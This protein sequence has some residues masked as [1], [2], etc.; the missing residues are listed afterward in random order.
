MF[1]FWMEHER[2]GELTCR[3]FGITRERIR[4]LVRVDDWAKRADVI[5][6]KISRSVDKAIEQEQIST[7]KILIKCL[8]KEADA[9]LSEDRK[10]EGDGRLVI[11]FCEIID[12]LRG[13]MPQGEQSADVV[14]IYNDLAT[15]EL[16]KRIETELS[17]IA[18]HGEGTPSPSNS[19]LASLDIR[20]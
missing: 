17:A 2:N 13:V 16:L 14:N 18:R 8:T 1:K 15:G 11:A 12:K 20:S 6:G 3:K 19:R 10:C 7:V 5:D 9:F 4:R